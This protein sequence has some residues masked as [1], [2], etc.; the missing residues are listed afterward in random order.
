MAHALTLASIAN[1]DNAIMRLIRVGARIEE[2]RDNFFKA[3]VPLEIQ[4]KMR[5]ALEESIYKAYTNDEK[6]YTRTKKTKDAVAFDI[7]LEGDE[8][9]VGLKFDGTIPQIYGDDKYPYAQYFLHFKS[10]I[11]ESA[12]PDRDFIWG[13]LGYY[14]FVYEKYVK[15][16][17]VDLVSKAVLEVYNVS[18]Q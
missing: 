16:Q 7:I 12:M 4:D 2:K 18:K 14:F 1:I 8:K 15:V 5:E 6:H 10:F 3:E 11:H 17:V 9:G 13:E